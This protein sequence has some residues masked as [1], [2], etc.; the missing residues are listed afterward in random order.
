MLPPLL[1]SMKKIKQR[2]IFVALVGG[3]LLAS[4]LPEIL[5]STQAVIKQTFL[6]VS[7]P[8]V[9]GFGNIAQKIIQHFGSDPQ[10]LLV[11]NKILSICML[12]SLVAYF[13]LAIRQT[14]RD[15]FNMCLMIIVIFFVFTPGFGFQYLLWPLPFLILT[16]RTRT[17]YLFTGLTTFAFIHTYNL[18]FTPLNSVI[19]FLQTAFYYKTHMLYPYD[20]YFPLWVLF[21]V[22]YVREVSSFYLAWQRRRTSV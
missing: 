5:T 16:R 19:N 10:G 22:F 8:G 18:F 4:L 1:W 13:I 11:V 9:W 14:K 7:T 15:F 12:A 20:L 17:V 21:L 2:F 3:L 6:Y